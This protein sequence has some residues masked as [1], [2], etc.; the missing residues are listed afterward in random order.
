MTTRPVAPEPVDVQGVS[1][2]KENAQRILWLRAIAMPAPAAVL[3]LASLVYAIPAPL[4]QLLVIIGVLILVD[5]WTWWRLR[6]PRPFG[7]GAFFAQMLIDVVALT[8]TLYYTG[9]ASNPFALFFLL[10]VMIT[11]TVLPKAYTWAIVGIS[12]LCYTGLM[13]SARPLAVLQP[14][15]NQEIFDLHVVGMWLGFVLIAVLVAHFV[16]NMGATLRASDRRL[17]R[18]REQA[19]QDEQLR[20]LATLAA[21]AAHE[22]STPLNTMRLIV[23]E[24]CAELPVDGF[25]EIHDQLRTLQGQIDRC[26]DALSVVSKSAGTDQSASLRAERPEDFLGR[27]AAQF[28]N[29]RPDTRLTLEIDGPQPGPLLAIE[30]TLDQAVTNLI[31][32]ALNV[33]PRD[34]R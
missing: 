8:G 34:V 1:P 20:S 29:L 22:I 10:P 4:T 25:P 23:E 18:L 15:N 33:S 13:V 24:V 30:R 17:A 14:G 28:R 26:K 16:A 3:V 2:L 27:I 12:I 32:N 7:H 11:A 31:D 21:G 6:Q 9:G 19:L 5:P